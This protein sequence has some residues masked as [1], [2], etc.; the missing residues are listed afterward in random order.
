MVYGLAAALG[1]ALGGFM[2]DTLGWRWEFGIQVFPLAGCFALA[3]WTMPPDLGLYV[4]RETFVEA[5]KA[6]D[7]T[8][9]VLL[10]SSTTFLILGLVRNP[11]LYSPFKSHLAWTTF[12][13]TLVL[14][15]WRQRTTM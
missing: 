4:E 15:P 7:W 11:L 5:V 8:G 9:T 10:I 14:E 12:T 6:F 2:A 13:D 1:A 3:A